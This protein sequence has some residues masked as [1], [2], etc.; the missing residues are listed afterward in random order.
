[1]CSE[2]RS[3]AQAE[4]V[5]LYIPNSISEPGPG[6]RIKTRGAFVDPARDMLYLEPETW[7]TEALGEA[8]NKAGKSAFY[9][10]ELITCFQCI[11][12]VVI[13]WRYLRNHNLTRSRSLVSW[14][15]YLPRVEEIT[16]VAHPHRSLSS[17]NLLRYGLREFIPGSMRAEAAQMILGKMGSEMREFVE[18]TKRANGLPVLKIMTFDLGDEFLE[19]P[20]KGIFQTMEEHIFHRATMEDTQR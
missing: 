17:R 11:S 12:K 3:V 9:T 6:D 15:R 20:D 10:P 2:S 4:R 19:S 1:V 13:G 8:T 7:F 18:A 5:Y 14:I 16:I